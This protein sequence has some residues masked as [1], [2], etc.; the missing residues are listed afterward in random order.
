MNEEIFTNLWLVNVV[1][2]VDVHFIVDVQYFTNEDEAI[3]FVEKINNLNP[4]N[5]CAK[6]PIFLGAEKTS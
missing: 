5:I 4:T 6:M 1:D 2:E 3:A